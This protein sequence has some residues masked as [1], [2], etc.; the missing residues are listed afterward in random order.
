MRTHARLI[1]WAIVIS[2]LGSLPLGTLNLSIAHLAFAHNLTGAGL[3]AM[4]AIAV[5]VIL[6]RM[7]LLAV[8]R[9]EQLQ[10]LFRFFSV[11]TALVLLLL[12]FN[13]LWA[14]WRQLP[15]SVALP[16]TDLPPLLS[17]LLLSVINPLHLPFWMGWTAVLRSRYI[18]GDAP[19]S[20]NYYVAAI[21]VGTS[22]AFAAY[23]LAG[24]FLVGLLQRS[25][26]LLNWAIG[27]VLLA[28]ALAQLY[29]SFWRSVRRPG[30][31]HTGT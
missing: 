24:H 30:P 10:R 17:G 26:V 3:F 16:F 20:Y 25:Q 27:V 2:F 15:F 28:T 18:L 13:S 29:K 4:A 6:V 23:G 8:R 5:E 31:H 11:V 21:G 22:L 14:A 12:A 19:G 1:V 9:L 7:A